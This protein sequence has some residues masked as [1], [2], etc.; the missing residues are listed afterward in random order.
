M[1]PLDKLAALTRSNTNPAFE[2]EYYHELAEVWQAIAMT[3]MAQ[4]NAVLEAHQM[5]LRPVSD[6]EMD[7][8]HLDDAKEIDAIAKNFLNK[9]T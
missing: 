1:N 6:I 9:L 2:L 4:R 3:A 7:S 8:I 5:R